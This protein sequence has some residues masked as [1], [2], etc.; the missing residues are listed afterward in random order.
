ME[1]GHL[2]WGEANF[3]GTVRASGANPPVGE[4]GPAFAWGE[5]NLSGTLKAG[6]ATFSATVY[7]NLLT[8]TIL[9]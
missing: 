3:G 5:A 2:A 4:T 8:Y 7:S 1:R 6:G 9:T